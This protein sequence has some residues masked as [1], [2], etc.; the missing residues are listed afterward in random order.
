MGWYSDQMH[1]LNVRRYHDRQPR[2][3]HQ[4]NE[5]GLMGCLG[6]YVRMC[7]SIRYHDRQL[8]HVRLWNGT[9]LMGCLGCYVQMC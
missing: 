7:W 2:C 1:L 3:V 4:W 9:A 6:Y 8:H 5:M